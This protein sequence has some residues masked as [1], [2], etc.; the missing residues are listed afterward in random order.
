MAPVWIMLRQQIY[1]RL[2]ML[3]RSVVPVRGLGVVTE[4]TE[5]PMPVVRRINPSPLA[6]RRQAVVGV[7]GQAG[8]IVR[9]PVAEERKADHVVVI[10]AKTAA[11]SVMAMQQKNKIATCRRVRLPEV[12]TT[13]LCMPVLPAVLRINLPVLPAGHGTVRMMELRRPLAVTIAQA[14]NM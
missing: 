5:A 2:V 8:A 3:R 10:E 9:R 12:A 4:L 1:A 6:L 14:D 11:I 13:L 7:S